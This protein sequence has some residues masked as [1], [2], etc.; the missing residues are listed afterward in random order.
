MFNSTVLDVAIGLI[1]T[2]LAVSLAV[3]A[4]V[5]AIASAM[6]W[7]SS[8]LLQGIKDLLNDQSFSGLARSIYN[9]ALVN[10]Q[11]AGTAEDEKALKHP[12]AY[13]DPRLFADALVDVAKV[14]K[15][16]P[17]NMKS[18]IDANVKDPQLN[19][20]L[21]GVVDQTAGDLSKMREELAAWFSNSMDRV[22]GVY[23]RKTQLWSFAIALIMVV[24]LNVSAISIGQAL[25]LQP[26]LVKTIGPTANLDPAG[27]LS[28]LENLDFPIGW[29]YVALK[30]LESWNG[31]TMLAGWLITAVATLFGAP[32]WFDLLQQFVRLKGSGPS[33]AE[34]VSGAGAAD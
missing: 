22:S 2:F 12:P 10:P 21:K 20:L 3:G 28:V 8:T 29:S 33:P 5:E 4:I 9:H 13:M 7:R 34:K 15:D 19:I 32:F 16:S 27:T 26:M 25:W 23:K 24:G 30:N 11:D 18:I 17:D 1:F 31:L 6:K 14:T